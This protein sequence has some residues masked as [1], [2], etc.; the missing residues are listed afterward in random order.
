MPCLADLFCADVKFLA[1]SRQLPYATVRL[2]PPD[3]S[4]T[5]VIRSSERAQ[6]AGASAVAKHTHLHYL[7][8][9]TTTKKHTIQLQ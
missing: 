7:A 6:E 3:V 4:H 2:S 5:N 1:V 8:K 9:K